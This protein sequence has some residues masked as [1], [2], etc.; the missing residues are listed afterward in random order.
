MQFPDVLKI[1]TKT[2]RRQSLQRSIMKTSQDLVSA[3]MDNVFDKGISLHSGTN[4]GAFGFL[5]PSAALVD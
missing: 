4:T 1:R 5:L 2:S 3:E